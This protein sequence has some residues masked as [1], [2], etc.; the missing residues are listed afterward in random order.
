M[1]VGTNRH[2]DNHQGKLCFSPPKNTSFQNAK[3]TNKIG[4]LAEE[5]ILQI[6][7]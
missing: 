2:T 6:F 5:N 7:S 4:Q 3:L 1:K